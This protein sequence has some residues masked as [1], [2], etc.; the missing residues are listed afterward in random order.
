[1]T[2]RPQ[3]FDHQSTGSTIWMLD[4]QGTDLSPGNSFSLVFEGSSGLWMDVE[5]GGDGAVHGESAEIP[6]EKILELQEQINA[7]VEWKRGCEHP[8]SVRTDNC[9]EE[10]CWNYRYRYGVNS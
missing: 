8:K 4:E 1:M 6:F 2:R 9:T 10:S 5:I 3:D 7:Y